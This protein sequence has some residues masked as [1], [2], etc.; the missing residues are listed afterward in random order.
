MRLIDADAAKAKMI[1]VAAKISSKINI[2]TFPIVARLINMFDCK[3]DFPTIDAALVRHGKWEIMDDSCCICSQ[4][5]ASIALCDACK[6]WTPPKFCP[7]CGA[8][9]DIKEDHHDTTSD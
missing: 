2:M 1:E 9:M 4:C 6:E 3:E 8:C 5:R 7:Y